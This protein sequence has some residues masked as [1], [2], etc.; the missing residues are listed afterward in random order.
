MRGSRLRMKTA[1]LLNRLKRHSRALHI[2]TKT[3]LMSVALLAVLLASASWRYSVRKPRAW[4]AGE[5]PVA[6]W[7]WRTEAPDESDVARAAAETRARVLF[8]RAGQF[9]YERGTVR[10]IRPVVGRFPRALELQLVYNATRPLLAEFER[11]GES[12][13]AARI[14]ETY[15]EDSAR[16]SREG[17]RVAGLQLDIDVPT[18][19][20]ARYAVVLRAVRERMPR[21]SQL[22][23]T[24]LPTWM[25]ASADL[26]AV[27]DAVDF[28]IPQCYGAHIPA[29]LDER[30]PIASHAETA[31][32]VARAR[33]LGK[34]FYAG[35]AAY[36]YALLYDS[37][38]AL[39][40]LRGDLDPARVA[41]DSNLELLE[42][43]P[44]ERAA[45][46]RSD[47]GDTDHGDG[48]DTEATHAS[49]WRYVYRVETDGVVDGL[50]VGAGDYLVIDMP[51]SASL[52]ACVRGV[53]EEAGEKL[54][55]ICLF[56]LPTGDD[57]AT[58]TLGQMS[59][60]LADV[61]P[62]A[63]AD[64][65][66]ARASN[67]AAPVLVS[68]VDPTPSNQL[69]V[70]AWN[71]G[72]AG[73]LKGSDAFT[74]DL[75]VPRGSL[76]GIARL[77]GFASVETFC[78]EFGGGAGG[79]SVSAARAGEALRP[80]ALR[81][82]SVLRLKSPTWEAGARLA[83]LISFEGDLPPALDAGISVALDDGRTYSHRQEIR[84]A[85]VDR[86]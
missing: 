76:R 83:A 5:A 35:L 85:D 51:S 10:R 3:A 53:R 1:L 47:A 17:A 59:A 48:D 24:G 74:L 55:G 8:M 21:G 26:G 64:V 28:W 39:V 86:R 44:F 63:V 6:F 31:R 66:L 20:L 30:A 15:V 57:P 54:L 36:A 84:L 61:Q 18:R 19:L 52:R 43:T 16:A 7:A 50:N 62:E 69:S 78:E 11:V 34:P 4:A 13:L 45:R 80:C 68:D 22:S 33:A 9:E 37:K 25:T 82:A 27:L 77:D 65:S 75:R 56:R 49:E 23:I 14:V 42:R 2:S 58:L 32:A 60:A 79:A 29:R 12:A 72:T 41:R 73:A 38:G 46:R 40:A 81:R 70:R 71:R 67:A